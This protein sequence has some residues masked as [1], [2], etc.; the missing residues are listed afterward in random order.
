MDSDPRARVSALP[1]GVWDSSSELSLSSAAIYTESAPSGAPTLKSVAAQSKPGHG[2]P[3]KGRIIAVGGGKGGVGKSLVTS[4]LGIC[5]AQHGKKVVVVDADL[6]GANLHTCLG[7][8][9]P[10]RTLSDFINRRVDSI[11]AVI[12][13][14]GVKNLGLISGAHDHPYRVQ[15][16]ILPKDAPACA[17]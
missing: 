11:E 13:E 7:Q 1:D 8:S 5:L 16:E 4:S 2:K 17:N 10:D 3:P 15:S 12:M 14:T 9:T 6:G